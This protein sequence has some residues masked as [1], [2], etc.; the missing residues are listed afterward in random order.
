MITVVIVNFKT[1]WLSVECLNGM[2]KY[3]KGISTILIDNGSGEKDCKL[4]RSYA[5]QK[6]NIRLIENPANIGHGPAMHL[7]MQLAETP[8]VFTLD[9]DCEILKGGF[10]EAMEK[11]L[12]DGTYAIGWL[13]YVNINGVAAQGT[14]DKSAFTPYV[15]PHAAL[16]T[17]DT[18]FSLYPFIHH[19]APCIMNMQAAHGRHVPVK[20]F[21]IQAYVKHLQAGTRRMFG[22]AWDIKRERNA[23]TWDKSKVYPI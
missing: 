20:D 16:W 21:N 7:G 10:L 13:R 2:D 5:E 8:L 14:F 22:G 1:A 12:E 23:G 17:R 3:Y 19:G 18:Y 15:H 11:E 4:L 6:E 9:S